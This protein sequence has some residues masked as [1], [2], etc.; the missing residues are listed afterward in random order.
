MKANVPVLLI[1]FRRPDT[2]RQVFEMIREAEPPQL[3]IAADGP[4]AGRPEE[5]RKCEQTRAVVEDVD[6]DCEVHRNYSDENLGCGRRPASAITWMFE[7]VDRAIILEDDCLP[8]PSFFPFCESVLER[9]EDVP[10]VMHVNGNTYGLDQSDW[11]D[12]SYGFGSYSQVWGWATWKRAWDHFDFEISDWPAFR[13]AGMVAS[14]DG[15]EAYAESR[16]Q[17]WDQVYQGKD[18]DVWDYQWHFAV[19]SRGGT[20]IVP[21]HNLVSNV[22][23]SDAATHTFDPHSH[24]AG[25][26]RQSLDFPIRHPPYRVTD[27]RI[28]EVYRNNMLTPSLKWRVRRKFKHFRR[29]FRNIT[30]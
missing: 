24:K 8:D 19:M 15:G 3:F 6:W 29:R 30:E 9:Y 25:I 23:F 18:R 7:H 13:D 10:E 27:V 4:Y 2:T 20:A 28:N 11:H 17:K 26:E 16:I 1:I 22:G 14:L 5:R 12:Y 21:R